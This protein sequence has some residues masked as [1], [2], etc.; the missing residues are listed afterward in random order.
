MK[1]TKIGK[2]SCMVHQ[3]D[4]TTRRVQLEVKCVPELWMNLFSLTKLLKD[5]CHSGDK[6]IYFYCNFQR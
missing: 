5:R 4:G 6:G 3:Q 1:A 2:V